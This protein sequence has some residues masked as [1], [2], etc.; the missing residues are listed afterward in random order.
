MNKVRNTIEALCAALGVPALA[1]PVTSHATDNAAARHAAQNCSRALA[2]QIGA[3]L[4]RRAYLP[5]QPDPY[6][7]FFAPSELSLTAVNP[8]SH[9][10]IAKAVCYYNSS[11]RMNGL[12]VHA[13]NPLIPGFMERGP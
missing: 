7:I 5:A 4:V 11:G 13:P 3:H 10:V 2:A 1:L 9:R 8:T 6:A 12:T